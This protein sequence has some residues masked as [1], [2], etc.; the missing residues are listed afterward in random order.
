MLWGLFLLGTCLPS[1][2]IKGMAYNEG[3][4]LVGPAP[5]NGR[6]EN[7]TQVQGDK[8]DASDPGPL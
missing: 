5:G 8:G 4:N 2:A 3:T 7:G 6:G 1:L